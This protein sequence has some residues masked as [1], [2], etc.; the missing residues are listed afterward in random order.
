VGEA[1]ASER[2]V[3]DGRITENE[4]ARFEREV[5]D[6]A[7]AAIALAERMRAVADE[8]A[9]VRAV[10]PAMRRACLPTIRAAHRSIGLD[11]QT[12]PRETR[13]TGSVEE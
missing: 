10:T 7:P 12:A 8:Q 11:Q 2:M 6:I 3:A 9:R 5:A 1:L 4:I 13:A